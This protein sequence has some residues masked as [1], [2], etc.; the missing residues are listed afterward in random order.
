MVRT[1]LE[2]LDEG[3]IDDGGVIGLNTSNGLCETKT[4]E[5]LSDGKGGKGVVG[6]Q[7]E[8]PSETHA[9]KAQRRDSARDCVDGLLAEAFGHHGLKM[10]NPIQAGQLHPLP[11]FVHNPPRVCAQWQLSHRRPALVYCDDCDKG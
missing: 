3:K 1:Y 11:A 9:V 8:G 2:G 7:V 5:G 4:L 6:G 10:R